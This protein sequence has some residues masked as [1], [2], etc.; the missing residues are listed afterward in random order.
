MELSTVLE[1]TESM[2]VTVLFCTLGAS[3]VRL[4]LGRMFELVGMGVAALSE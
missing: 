4:L 2:L 1:E 3:G